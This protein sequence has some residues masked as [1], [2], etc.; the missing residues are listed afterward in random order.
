MTLFQV[1]ASN[2][3]YLQSMCT[4]HYEPF[5]QYKSFKIEILKDILEISFLIAQFQ[6][7]CVI[8]WTGC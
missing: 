7:I 4:A 1:T 6:Q 8:L 3:I 5:I 2:H